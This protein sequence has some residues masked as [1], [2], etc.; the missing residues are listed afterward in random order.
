MDEEGKKD[1]IEKRVVV[2]RQTQEAMDT[3]M[4]TCECGHRRAMIRIYKCLYC[5]ESYCAVCAE[6]HFGQTREERAKERG[7]SF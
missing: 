4:V 3:G 5:D 6:V 7:Y 2:R 1:R